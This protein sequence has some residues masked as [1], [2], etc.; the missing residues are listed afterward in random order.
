MTETTSRTISAGTLR[1]V[2]PE[3]SYA[4]ILFREALR[5]RQPFPAAFR[6]AVIIN[7]RRRQVVKHGGD[8]TVDIVHFS[9]AGAK[10][11]RKHAM[12]GS[13]PLLSA[14]LRLEEIQ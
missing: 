9:F 11:A 13:E 7:L 8:A 12:S 10:L 2:R 3:S 14:P 6:S 4:V 5:H 1:M